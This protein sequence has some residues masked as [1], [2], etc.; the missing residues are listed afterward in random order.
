[1][2]SLLEFVG[3]SVVEEVLS[4]TLDKLMKRR[5][6]VAREILI[7]ELSRGDARIEDVGDKDEAAAM[8]FEYASAAQHGAGR[9][10]LRLL[11][12]VFAG[13][14]KQAPPLYADEFMRWSRILADL[15]REEIILLGAL[16]R[17]WSHPGARATVDGAEV[18]VEGVIKGAKAELA[19]DGK[20][21]ASEEEF[22]LTAAALIRTGLVILMSGYDGAFFP[23]T[24]SRLDSLL[25]IARIEDVLSEPD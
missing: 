22:D 17:H 2:V 14:L 6:K 15:S 9:R 10:N 19:G 18:D 24:T 25:R 5:A 21:F 11:A 16:H 13:M 7:D 4:I 12:Q 23:K 8:V 3:P 1:M 20:I